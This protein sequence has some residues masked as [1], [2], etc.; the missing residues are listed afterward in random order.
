LQGEFTAAEA[1]VALAAAP[2]GAA[3]VLDAY[4]ASLVGTFCALVALDF[5]NAV[6]GVN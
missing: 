6:L 1:S 4:H 2:N 3:A 5:F